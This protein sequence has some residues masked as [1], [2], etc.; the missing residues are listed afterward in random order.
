MP[1]AT[2]SEISFETYIGRQLGAALS[3]LDNAMAACPDEVW[4]DG[5]RGHAFWYIAYHTLFWLDVH[6]A[7]SAEGF[8][9]PSPF[10]LEELDPAGVLPPRT[11]TAVELRGYAGH[12]RRRLEAAIA[13][14]TV[15]RAARRCRFPWGEPTYA[16]LLLYAM[17]HVQ[18][19]AGQLNLLLRQRAG[20]APGWVAR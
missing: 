6:L 16:E 8:L 18:H 11:C 1:S 17:R 7:G 5:S 4:D 3:M 9:P 12:C 14:L 20:S 10:G 2:P 13:G 19:H 15:E